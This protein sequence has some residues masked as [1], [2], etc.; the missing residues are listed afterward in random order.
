MILDLSHDIE[1]TMQTYPGDPP[2]RKDQSLTVDECGFSVQLL[3]MGT[4]AGT[5]IDAPSHCVDKALAIHEVDL[6]VLVGPALVVDVSGLKPRE[7]ITMKHLRGGQVEGR[8]SDGINYLAQLSSGS[9]R[10]VLFRTGWCQYWKT[11]RYVESPYLTE[12]VARTL[13]DYGVRV[14]GVDTLSP[15]FTAREDEE[16]GKFPV[17]HT[18]L[19]AGGYIV[20]N[21][22]NLDAILNGEYVVSLLPLKVVGGDGCPIRAVAWKKGENS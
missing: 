11:D 8:A 19:G 15:D 2:F 18:V 9:Y 17:H 22:R 6:S 14:I 1:P 10:I 4:H 16:P 13:L 3:H 12:E 7:E 21:L 5:H 20:E